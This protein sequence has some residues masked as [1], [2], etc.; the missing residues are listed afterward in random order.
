MTWLLVGLAVLLAYSVTQLS[1]TGDTPDSVT[2]DTI[3]TTGTGHQSDGSLTG[4]EI[5]NDPSTWPG[6]SQFYNNGRVWD[7]CTAVALAEGFNVGRGTA[8]Y[9]LN[10]PG[11]V[12]PGD[13]NGEATCGNPQTHGGSS[14][15]NFCTAE[16]GFIALYLK[17]MRIVSGAS[18]TYPKT[19]T[20]AQ[21]AKQY[22][23]DSSNWL[24][25]VTTYLG[26]SATSTPAQY[27]GV[28]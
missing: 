12:S 27:A 6:A 7:I 26:V 17:F 25:N 9:D 15:I 5:T 21:V 13:E 4:A 22:A 14:I 10:N 11:D 28:A 23:G 16:N 20:W 8:P 19:W 2:S 24:T 3:M 1:V 18:T